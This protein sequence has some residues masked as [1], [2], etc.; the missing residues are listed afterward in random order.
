M[1]LA[2]AAAAALAG[3]TAAAFTDR[4][5]AAATFVAATSF[6]PSLS[7]SLGS[8]TCGGA[9]STLTVP[10]GG[11]PV[12]GTVVVIVGLRS[13][14][15]NTAGPVSGSDSRGNIYVVDAD[16]AYGSVR[17][18]VLHARVTAA[19]SAGD[20]VTASHPDLDAEAVTGGTAGGLVLDASNGAGGTSATPSA[21]LTTSF[22]Q[23][24]LVGVEGH[25]NIRSVTESPGWTTVVQVPAD[26]GG[27]SKQYTL[28]AAYRKVLS[29]GGYTYAPTISGPEQWAAVI[30]GYR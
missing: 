13:T 30:V 3:A 21:S 9:S 16:H 17:T 2:V 10:A 29:A 25:Q 5:T 24:I 11:V 15:G 23:E 8:T 12:G 14:G 7:G 6:A 19:L 20:A 27:A 28:H 1:A 26:C 22:A 4:T 18:V